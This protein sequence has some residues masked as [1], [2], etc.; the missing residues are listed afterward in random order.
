MLPRTNRLSRAADFR[1]VVG[2]GTRVGSSTV[3]IHALLDHH[4]SIRAGF[5]VSK[6]VGN[7]VTRNRVKRRLRHLVAD[8]LGEASEGTRVVVRATSAASRTPERLARD[9][10]KAW[11]RA[12]GDPPGMKAPR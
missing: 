6:A 7:A 11:S 9:L 2:R 12:V 4:G 5:V 3:V 1:R 8:R 10:Q